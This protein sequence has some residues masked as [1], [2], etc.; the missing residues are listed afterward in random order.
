MD[1]LIETEHG[2]YS[3]KDLPTTEELENFYSNKYYQD[4]VGN[5]LHQYSQEELTFFEN[6]AKVAEYIL[7]DIKVQTLLDVGT[8]EGFFANYFYNQK[9]DVTTLDY[10]DYG[11]ATHNPQIK[12]TILKDD[13]FKSIQNIIKKT[14]TYGIVNLSNVLEHV[15]NP[16]SLLSDL[17]YLLDENSFLRISVPNDFSNFQNFLMNEKYTTN[18][19]VKI[20]NHLHYFTFES[21]EKLLDSCG[22]DIHT[23]IGEFPIEVFLANEASNYAHDRTVGKSAHNARIKTDNFLFTQGINEYIDYFKSSAKIG[24]TRQV[25]IYAQK[26]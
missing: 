16:I 18:T 10:S 15:I 3:V 2:Y 13:I 25:V 1:R 11:I 6:K 26:R 20:P 14:H 24:F 9:W 4:N 19:W 23:S 17:K 7:R 12:H 22:Y 5:H 8:G 21:L